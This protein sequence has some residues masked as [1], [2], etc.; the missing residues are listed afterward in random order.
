MDSFAA[1]QPLLDAYQNSIGTRGRRF[2][3]LS[4]RPG[5]TRPVHTGR[6]QLQQQTAATNARSDGCGCGLRGSATRSMTF[7]E[8]HSATLQARG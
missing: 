5:V 3:S 8:A 1:Q 4:P 2:K 6:E 7:N